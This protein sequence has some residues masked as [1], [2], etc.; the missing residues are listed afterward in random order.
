MADHPEPA[1]RPGENCFELAGVTQTRGNRTVLSNLTVNLP[2]GGLTAL[3]GPSGSGKTSLLRL[4]NRLD[5]PVAGEIR[6]RGQALNTYKVRALRRRIG[7]VFQA[8][9]MF[10]GSVAGNLST[11]HLLGRNRKEPIAPDRIQEVLRMVELDPDFA[12]REARDLSGGEKQRVALARALITQPEVLL[13]D[14]PTA[15]L[16]PEVA[17]RLIHTL[18]RLR[19]TTGLVIV[20]VTHRLAEARLASTYIV[21]LEAGQVLEAGPT[22]QLL[23]TPVHDRTRAYIAF[24]G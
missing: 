2:A 6:F 13:L 3:I 10:P 21:M 23:S 17:D 16:D 5:D 12:S 8:P 19:D 14:E 1:H 15:A 18:C 24:G 4:L 7:F 9:T 11:A 20:M 22:A